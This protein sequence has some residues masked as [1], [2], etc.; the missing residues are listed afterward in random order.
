MMESCPSIEEL[1]R[2]LEADALDPGLQ[3]HLEGCS[4][5]RQAAERVRDNIALFAELRGTGR[6]ELAAELGYAGSSSAPG[7]RI[8]EEIHRG[9]QGVVYRALQESTR[10]T[11]AIKVLLEGAL[12]SEGKR[13][14]FEREI[15]VV[16]GLRHPGIVTVFDSGRLADGRHFFAME[17]IEGETLGV[18]IPLR[19][20]P[21]GDAEAQWTTAD[22]LRLFARI[23]EAVQFAHQRGVMHR[24]LKPSNILVDDAGAPHVL[25]FGLAKATGAEPSEAVSLTMTNEFMGTLAYASPEQLRGDPALVDLRTDVYS[26]GVILYEMLAGRSPYPTSERMVDLMRAISEV[27]PKPPSSVQTIGRRG[28]WRSRKA[29]Q[30]VGNELDTI[31]LKA[32]AKDADRRYQSAGALGRDVERYLAGEAIDARRDSTW[33]V[34]RKAIGR[35]KLPFGL[36]AG[37]LALLIGS[38]IGMT[39]LWSGQ[40]RATG[41]AS[42]EARDQGKITQFLENLF[43]WADPERSSGEDVLVRD[44]L[45]RG[46]ERIDESLPEQPELQARLLTRMGRC[47]TNL[48]LYPKAIPLLER[49]LQL[50]I[51]HDGDAADSTSVT[52]GQLGKAYYYAGR[53]GAEALL[54]AAFE[55]QERLNGFEDVETIELAV[56][57]A[58]VL[59]QSGDLEGADELYERVNRALDQH[60]EE[61]DQARANL[62]TNWAQTHFARRDFA[63]TIEVTEQALAIQRRIFPSP[64]PTQIASLNTLAISF[65]NLGRLEECERAYEE[66]IEQ[67][68]KVYGEQSD[69]YAIFQKNRGRLLEDLGE[70]D[71]AERI[72]RE[73]LEIFRATVPET[74]PHAISCLHKLATLLFI[75]KEYEES[76]DLF[77]QE[78]P[79]LPDSGPQ[80]RSR[81]IVAL[82]LLCRCHEALGE[83]DEA[84]RRLREARVEQE[85]TVGLAVHQVHLAGIVR[86]RGGVEEARGLFLEAL[87]RFRAEAD[88][89]HYVVLCLYGLGRIELEAGE[90]DEAERLLREASSVTD[91][92]PDH[93]S[94]AAVASALGACIAEAGGEGAEELLQSGYST[95]AGRLGPIHVETRD[96]YRR[97]IYFYEAIGQPEKAREFERA[98]ADR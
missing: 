20:S 77:L 18:F 8:L 2:L 73:A 79:L 30:R 46:V 16:A 62:L 74:H 67:C 51:E 84:E 28:S 38:T 68:R 89:G 23:C 5:C 65:R 1:E 92:K 80:M 6:S 78:L 54:R 61:H 88:Y 34:V 50:R 33:Y 27:D 97:V 55:T 17:H 40:V 42:I 31:V 93:W 71:E 9:G 96:A 35:H 66:L 47:Y 14:R 41:K 49:A 44:L 86:R 87:E 85:G 29:L 4:D 48:G 3:S 82:R 57:L 22:T 94:R 52:R 25:D 32:M 76:R 81:R 63:Q 69:R 83:L 56:A 36:A 91:G 13:R 72:Y 53:E 19:S 60:P 21:Q 64:H 37:L 75:R 98:A 58:V 7:Y 15:E 95:L 45:D 11:V 10:R 12:A 90:R 24:D 59:T 70:Q 39:V 26:L 43:A